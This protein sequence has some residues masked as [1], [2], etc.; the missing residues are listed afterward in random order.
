MSRVT[1]KVAELR[2]TFVE[3]LA[4]CVLLPHICERKDLI[5]NR[6]D[7]LAIVKNVRGPTSEKNKK[8]FLLFREHDLELNSSAIKR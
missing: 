7:G 8:Y 2:K 1:Y 4:K 3:T 5:L 6:D